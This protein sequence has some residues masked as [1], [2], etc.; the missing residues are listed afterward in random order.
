MV[1][2]ITM[3]MDELLKIEE[4][5]QPYKFE[6]T[7]VLNDLRFAN[8]KVIGI[9]GRISPKTGHIVRLAIEHEMI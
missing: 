7:L 1:S 3:R 9:T 2:I 4:L 6:G 5:T 8:A